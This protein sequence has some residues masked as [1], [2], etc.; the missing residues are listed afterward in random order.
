MVLLLLPNLLI[1]SVIPK[2][3]SE[4]IQLTLLCLKKNLYPKVAL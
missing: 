3:L 1:S 4:E 2:A